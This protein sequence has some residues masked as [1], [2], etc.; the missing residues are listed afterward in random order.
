[1]TPQLLY[2]GMKQARYREDEEKYSDLNS[3]LD[4]PLPFSQDD[5]MQVD[6]EAFEDYMATEDASEDLF[7]LTLIV[8]IKWRVR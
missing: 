4:V 7:F 3:F 6:L 2:E 8:M 1:M 5:I